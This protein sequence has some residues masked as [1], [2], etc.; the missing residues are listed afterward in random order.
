MK[1][2]KCKPLNLKKTFKK[3]KKV[4]NTENEKLKNLL[5]KKLIGKISKE[6]K[7]RTKEH[8]KTRPVQLDSYKYY[9]ELKKG[10]RYIT[11]Y[12]IDCNNKHHKML[13]LESMCGRSK[14]FSLG[15]FS[16]SN[17]EKR[18]CYS[19]DRVGNREYSLFYKDLTASE[20]KQVKIV[21]KVAP[22]CV[23]SSDSEKIYYIRYD[24]AD[25]R[26]C[27]VYVYDL[28]TKKHEMIYEEKDHKYQL[29]LSGTS[30]N[31]FIYI[32]CISR[33]NVD[34]V[35]ITPCGLKQPFKRKPDHF[36]SLHHRQ[37][38][39]YV[40]EK[41]NGE[42]KIL[43]SRDLNKFETFLD[44]KANKTIRYIF[45]KQKYL[46]IATREEGM[47][48]LYLYNFCNQTFKRMTFLKYRHH[49]FLPYMYN[50]NFDSD[51]LYVK[52]SSFTKPNS[53][54]KINMAELSNEL[55]YER[56]YKG[57][58]EKNYNEKIVYV[59]KDLAITMV[60]KNKLLKNNSKCVLYG[61]GSYGVVLESSFEK[62]LP[63]LLDRGFIY[64]FAHIRGSKFNG[65][66]WYKDGKML[67]K[68]NTFIDFI[69][70]AKYLI[71]NNYTSPSRLVIWGRSAGGLLIGS[72]INMAPELF[73]LA[74]LGVPFVDVVD[75][76]N[77][78]CQ[79]LTTEE[80]EEW[81][82]PKNKRTDAYQRSYSPL[83]NINLSR[84]Y[85]NVYIYSNVEDSL[86]PYKSVMN[87]YDRLKTAKVFE[88]GQ[89]RLLLDIDSKYG[90]GQAS[91]RYEA[92]DEM[93]KIYA[94]ILHF[95]Q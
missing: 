66:S 56:R 39:W 7:S 60:Y 76:M 16:I 43:T 29:T 17:N 74:I 25:M 57:Y 85:P 32:S 83:D 77:N 11:H 87:Y 36:Y 49:F 58:N 14:F 28:N 51:E 82:N 67:N 30:D 84:N 93:A 94:I 12:V 79:P 13:D 31:K 37:D 72:V 40:L 26:P 92:M 8:I 33:K 59:N 53:L 20:N 63:S 68:K 21:D 64:C 70:C 19:V 71:S 80:Y 62:E 10:K 46:L 42:S 86:V 5:D 38:V 6:F 47:L 61:Y 18:V 2:K 90:H 27:K 41:I 69:A 78:E 95:I 9:Y 73:N 75:T 15:G 35:L 81:G 88:S 1:T 89:K 91:D 65:Y 34:V 24:K 3:D 52:Y 48:Y 44:F 45:M 54:I 22:D 50:F 23:W 55:I 4:I